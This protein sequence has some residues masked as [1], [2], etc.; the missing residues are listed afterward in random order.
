MRPIDGDA[1]KD[2]FQM[3]ADDDWNQTTGTTWGNAFAEAADVVDTAPPIDA[4]EVVRCRDC[5]V[6][7]WCRF[8]QGLGLEGFC[9]QGKRR[10][11]DETD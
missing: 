4:V 9:S 11:E 10:E 3:F 8:A 6:L 2:T 7:P 5:I 1:L